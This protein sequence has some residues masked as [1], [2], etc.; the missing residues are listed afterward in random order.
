MTAAPAM[1]YSADR[2]FFDAALAPSDASTLPPLPADRLGRHTRWVMIAGEP[3]VYYSWTGYLE[4]AEWVD[5]DA[6]WMARAIAQHEALRRAGYTPPVRG[7]HM[8]DAARHGDVLRLATWTDSADGRL[9]L[10]AA[11]AFA[12][13]LAAS[14]I[15]RGEYAWVS[16]G[17][18]G[19]IDEL[20]TEYTD[21]ILEVSLVDAPYHKH[22]S[23]G[24]P[25]HILREAAQM[26][27]KPDTTD[28]AA[29]DLAALIAALRSD[30]DALAARVAAMEPDDDAE[31]MDDDEAED[32][33][34]ADGPSMSAPSSVEAELRERIATLERDK[35][36]AEYRAAAPV[37]AQLT[38]TPEMVDALFTLRCAAPEAHDTLARAFT[39]PAAPAP[40]PTPP[41]PA[42]FSS[43]WGTRLG[44]S[45]GAPSEE[46]EPKP[47]PTTPEAIEARKGELYAE[48]KR[49]ASGDAARAKALYFDAC[50][51]EGLA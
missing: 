48:A 46:S 17:V 35:A 47:A 2:R 24:R 41:A 28:D 27:D 37:G 40:A 19:Y 6:A 18:G 14:R 50:R 49:K 4:D 39:L 10:L 21:A 32:A 15:E 29:P 7:M 26:A 51:A 43:I 31:S 38:L 33:P 13:P 36:R 22:L 12:D 20:G 11:L 16:M 45:G 44:H 3:G 30:Y 5:M 8:A 34:P 42:Q 25:G 9:K 1:T 23:G